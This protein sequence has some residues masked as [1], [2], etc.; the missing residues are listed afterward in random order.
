MRL[1]QEDVFREL[2]LLPVWRA[3]LASVASPQLEHTVV[4]EAQVETVIPAEQVVTVADEYATSPVILSEEIPPALEKIAVAWMWVA[5]PIKDSNSQ[6]LFDGM[7]HAMRL[8]KE[9]FVLVNKRSQMET[10]EAK[11]MVLLGLNVANA[12]LGQ[13]L[14]DIQALR[15][16]VH[17]LGKT[18]YVVTH[19]LQ[20]MLAQPNLKKEVWHDLCLL[21]DA[22]VR[23]DSA[24]TA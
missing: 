15:G 17:S 2:E 3:Q 1:T 23:S 21:L 8:Q 7:L 11:Y 16:K 20:A 4:T 9:D 13:Q 10:Y 19:T 5:S 12:V 18:Q 14:A 6:S 24:S 22:S